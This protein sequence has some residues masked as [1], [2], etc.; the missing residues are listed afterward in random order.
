MRRGG[1]AWAGA[2]AL[3]LAQTAFAATFHLTTYHRPIRTRDGVTLALYRYANR[4]A[5]PAVLLVPG[6]GMNRHAF[7]LEGTGLAPYLQ[8]QGRD[9]FVIEPRGVGASGGHG[10]WHLSDWIRADLPAAVAAVQR[11]HPGQVDLIVV[12]FGGTLALAATTEELAGRVR[13]VVAFSTPALPE[14]PNRLLEAVL[15]H[16]GALADLCVEPT[17][18]RAFELLYAYPGR[19]LSASPCVL[20]AAVF[21]NL[22]EPAAGEWLGWMRTGDLTLPDGGTLSARLAR[23]ALPTL[24]FLPQGDNL[25]HAEFAS[26]LRTLAPHARIHEHLLNRLEGTAEDYSHLSMLLGSDAPKDLF[27]PLLEFLDGP[28]TE[29]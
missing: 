15:T 29:P 28:E 8:A 1:W 12:G 2:V 17:G 11:A 3:A 19:F 5:R 25:A 21:E 4:S 9:V 24:L 6:L 22:G 18:A 13:R 14:L 10:A 20:D 26:P 23:Y 7:D 16:G 27:A